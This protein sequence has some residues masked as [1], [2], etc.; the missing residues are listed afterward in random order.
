MTTCKAFGACEAHA[1]LTPMHIERRALR[2][3]DVAID[4]DYCGICH[5]DAH[6]VHN[7]WGTTVYPCV[8]GHEIV[9]RVSAVGAH[10]TRYKPGDRVAVGCL[11]DSCQACPSCEGGQEQNCAKGPTATYNGKDRHTG[12]T[13]L[14]GYSERIVVREQFVLRVPDALDVRYAGPLLC[15]GITVWTPLRRYGVGEG[16]KIAVVGLGGLGHM[17]VKLAVALGAEVTVI[18][19][20]ASKADDARALG[21]SDVLLSKDPK[22]MQAAANRFDFILDTIPTRHNVNPYLMLLGRNGVLVLVGALEPLE[23]V[24]GALLVINNR[25]IAGSLIGGLPA[26]QELLDF[27]A[28]HNVLPDCEIVDVHEINTAFTRMQANDVK[29][30][31]V[32]DMATLH[33]VK[34]D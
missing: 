22:A 1:D 30:R 2:E 23:A 20:S 6:A 11:V 14:G 16:S 31:F 17:A 7:D 34:T 33:D 8:P 28:E 26:T 21:A 15:A 32:I 27:C 3:H 5:S 25:S 4:I 29:Y 18:T 12:E 19:T 9:G 10:V 13:T 24:H